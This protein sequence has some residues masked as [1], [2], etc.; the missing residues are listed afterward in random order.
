MSLENS[1]TS[2]LRTDPADR[3]RFSIET[4]A[5]NKTEMEKVAQAIENDDIAVVAGEPGVGP[6]YT[7]WKTRRVK[8]GE[9]KRIGRIK[10]TEK[11][12]KSVIGRAA[13]FHESVH[14]LMDIN[15]IRI[16]KH[17]HEVIAY[18][19]DAMYLHAS[20]LPQKRLGVDAQGRAIFD[21]AFDLVKS[22]KMRLNRQGA[23]LR[24]SDCNAL[25]NAIKAHKDYS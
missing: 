24:W 21:A 2:V 3:I 10:V 16:D 4:I 15:D 11:S 5:V 25:I 19:A 22:R 8:P 12:A 20:K 14:A 1:V 9:K 18:V 23:R 7:S 17:Q 6:S 13:I